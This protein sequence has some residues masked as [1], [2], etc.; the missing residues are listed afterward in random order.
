MRK[1]L[2]WIGALVGATAPVVALAQKASEQ[3]VIVH[4]AYG[5]TDLQALFEL[6]DQLESAIS[7]AGIGEYDGNEVAV[8]GSDGYLYMYGPD[9]DKLFEVIQP[10][11]ERSSFMHGAEVRKRYGSAQDGVREVVL[12]IAS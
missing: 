6:E 12:K 7:A 1:I 11:L 8:D 4:F 5:S 10:I 2:G 9:A 3:A